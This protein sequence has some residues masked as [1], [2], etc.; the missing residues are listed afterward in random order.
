M[1]QGYLLVFA[2]TDDSSF[3]K[4]DRVR[5]E[6]IKAQLARGR[7]VPIF[8]VGTKADLASERS[9]SEKEAK[10]KA[11]AWDSKYFECSAKTS[12]NIEPIFVELVR[13]VLSTTT[14]PTKGGGGGSVFAGGAAP[15]V[16]TVKP[17]ETKRSRCS[18]L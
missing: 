2:I 15:K 9:V 7:R 18:I 1:L 5:D 13:E 17:A 11:K 14:D 6:I 8:L 3:A 12:T 16:E 10:A 4:L